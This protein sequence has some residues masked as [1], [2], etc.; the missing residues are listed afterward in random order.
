RVAAGR[1]RRVRAEAPDVEP[2][3]PVVIVEVRRDVRALEARAVGDVELPTLRALS[4]FDDARA[5]EDLALR[6]IEAREVA[7]RR[8]RCPDEAVA[9]DID[10]ARIDA[11][12]GHLVDLGL[13]R[14]GWVVAEID[15]HDVARSVLRRAPHGVVDGAR[16][17]GIEIVPDLGIAPRILRLI[18]D[19]PRLR[20][21]AVAVAVDDLRAPALRRLLVVRAI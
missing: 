15:A 7:A 3:D 8:E 1:Y 13:A 16:D 2:V 4:A 12:L 17:H 20:D 5:V 21:L 9:V 6:S 10:A 14:L 11:G 18:R 19:V